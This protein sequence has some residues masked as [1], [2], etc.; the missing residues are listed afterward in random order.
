MAETPSLLSQTREMLRQVY[1]RGSNGLTAKEIA[2]GAGVGVKWLE[3][4]V[5]ERT[6]D[7]GVTR[8][9][10]LHDFLAARLNGRA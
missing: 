7:P 2:A 3:G 4:F 1:G 8:V 9:Q 6:K 10:R 5:Q